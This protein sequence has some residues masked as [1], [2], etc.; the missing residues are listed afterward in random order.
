MVDV[1]IANAFRVGTSLFS[2]NQTFEMFLHTFQDNFV[3]LRDGREQ[4]NTPPVVARDTGAFFVILK[5]IPFLHSLRESQI[6][7]IYWWMKEVE[8]FR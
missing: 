6:P 1:D 2:T 3:S 5:M 7:R 4:A 8:L